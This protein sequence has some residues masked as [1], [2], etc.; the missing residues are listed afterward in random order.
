MTQGVTNS[1]GY[2]QTQK[3]PNLYF[4]KLKKLEPWLPRESTADACLATAGG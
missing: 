2:K 3:L 4:L 1:I